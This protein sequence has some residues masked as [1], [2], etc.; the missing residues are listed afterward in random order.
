MVLSTGV[1][2][3]SINILVKIDL[4]NDI[5]HLISYNT[6]D[7]YAKIQLELSYNNVGRRE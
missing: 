5:Q 4:Q 1:I 7:Y 3:L 6:K 2:V